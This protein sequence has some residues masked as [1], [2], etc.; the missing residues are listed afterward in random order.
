MHL[1]RDENVP[2][3]FCDCIFI[4]IGAIWF[5]LLVGISVRTAVQDTQNVP[6]SNCLDKTV[7]KGK[8]LVDVQLVSMESF[9]N[10]VNRHDKL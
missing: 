4:E 6:V 7:R 8:Y 9:W 10:P 1:Q 5:K 3:L 2:P